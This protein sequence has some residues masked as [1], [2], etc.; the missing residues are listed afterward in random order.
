MRTENYMATHARRGTQIGLE[1][2][3]VPKHIHTELRHPGISSGTLCQPI[4]LPMVERTSPVA[5]A[6]TE[7]TRKAGLFALKTL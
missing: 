2:E 5:G 4:G 6:A 7:L 1:A 3:L